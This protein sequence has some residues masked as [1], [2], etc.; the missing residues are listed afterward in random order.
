[1]FLSSP[2]FF[3][4]NTASIW[5]LSKALEREEGDPATEDYE[6]G[7]LDNSAL[8]RGIDAACAYL[9]EQHE[10]DHDFLV[11]AHEQRM[12]SVR[13]RL[14]FSTK[15]YTMR[16][17]PKAQI[18]RRYDIGTME[19]FEAS[20]STDWVNNGQHC[21]RCGQ[22][23]QEKNGLQALDWLD[24]NYAAAMNKVKQEFTCTN[25]GPFTKVQDHYEYSNDALDPMVVPGATFQNY[26][27][28]KDK[29]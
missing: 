23:A 14:K 12:E 29:P 3:G 28:R 10:I 16:N 9:Y 19:Q 8:E 18:E 6:P 15:P 5:L 13:A 25:C 11:L 20:I 24:E 26:K 21:P 17:M 1:V 22:W 2:K 27:R 4:V 7:E